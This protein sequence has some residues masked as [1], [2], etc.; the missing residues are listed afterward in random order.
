MAIAAEGPPD[1]LAAERISELIPTLPGRFRRE[2]AD[3]LVADYALTIDET[4][5]EVSISRGR[6]TVQ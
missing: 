5:F 3:G 1:P 2:A 4:C 6:R